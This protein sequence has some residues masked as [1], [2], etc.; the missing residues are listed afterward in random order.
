MSEEIQS[1]HFGVSKNQFT[2][3]TGV[4]Y[5][6]GNS[7]V[8][9]CT[10]SPSLSHDPGA[11]WALLKPIIEYAKERCQ[12]AR[13]IHFFSDGPSTQY[14]QKKNFYL[15]NK[16]IGQSI[17][18]YGT[19]SF[20]EAAHGKGPADGVGGAVKRKLDKLVAY[21]HDI[22]SAEA[23]YFLLKSQETEVK[24]FY[25]PEE[26]ITAIQNTIPNDLIS[27]PGTIRVHQIITQNC[28]GSI[29]YS[30]KTVTKKRS[31]KDPE[32]QSGKSGIKKSGKRKRNT[33][34]TDTELDSDVTY[35]ETSESEGYKISEDLSS[36]DER[37][38]TDVHAIKEKLKTEQKKENMIVDREI[39]ET[40][41]RKITISRKMKEKENRRLVLHEPNRSLITS[42]N[43][44]IKILS[45]I[46]VVN[47][48]D[49]KTGQFIIKANKN[50]VD[51][52]SKYGKVSK[53]GNFVLA[54][55]YTKH[56]KKNIDMSV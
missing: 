53:V 31:A 7:P 12:M 37:K 15:F 21:K 56:S 23:A 2:L 5:L 19:W 26:D 6:Q 29:F 40:E 11:I 3:H 9:F 27:L 33:D 20:F 44:N 13:A 4:I 32:N 45:D 14:C 24:I 25:I 30:D 48:L 42:C 47:V 18:D 17:F 51:A 43:T 41:E 22:P 16:I 28:D 8:S 55:F 54:K 38:C 52:S 35:A 39:I 46:E 49:E 10:I 36:E 50:V 1:A 34:S